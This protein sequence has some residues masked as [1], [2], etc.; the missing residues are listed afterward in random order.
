MLRR[1]EEGMGREGE[2]EGEGVL[3]V[4]PLALN[5]GPARMGIR[6]MG[7]ELTFQVRGFSYYRFCM[8]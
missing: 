7:K 5:K 3:K 2:T 4:G 6:T 8:P 1:R